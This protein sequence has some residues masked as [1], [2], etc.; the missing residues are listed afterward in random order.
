M[1]SLP[2]KGLIAVLVTPLDGEGNIDKESL[3]SLINYT[4]NHVHGFLT[5][6]SFTGEGF[7]LDSER[8]LKLIRSAMEIVRGRTVLLL[9]IT[10]NSSEETAENILQVE[11][12]RKELNYQGALFLFDCPLW[13]HSNRGLCDHY[14]KLGELTELGFILYNN[15]YLIA[16]L[17]KHLK[18]RNLRTN[19]V[20]RLSG[21]TQI[22][23]LKHS[24][25]AHRSLNYLRA[26]RERR[27]F[28][29]YDGH[30]P[31]FLNSP[32]AGGVVAAGA[33]ILPKD[34]REVV[35]SSLNPH[36]PEKED[37]DYCRHLWEIGQKLKV[38]FG[39]YSF[40]PP[41]IIKTALRYMGIIRSSRVVEGTAP[42]KEVEERRIRHL[43]TEYGLIKEVA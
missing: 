21:N 20:K 14:Q 39:A 42:V 3:K 18:R 29:F 27:G 41:A 17:K 15:P 25:E 36:D 23:G 1:N 11:R 24:G 35:S 33:N 6:A 13:Y 16:M 19:I 12:M 26:V 31:N 22:V 43:I 40:N 5:G 2:P 28:V 30:E 38:F 10:G 7:L 32:A 34:W 4:I 8:K 37:P 9:G